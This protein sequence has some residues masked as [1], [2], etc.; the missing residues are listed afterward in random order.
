MATDDFLHLWHFT[1]QRKGK[2]LIIKDMTALLCDEDILLTPT[3]LGAIAVV[4][5]RPA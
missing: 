1:P 3:G 4:H 2:Q 5:T